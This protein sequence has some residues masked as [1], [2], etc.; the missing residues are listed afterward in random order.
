MALDLTSL[1][2][3]V[4]SRENAL[5]FACSKD[6]LAALTEKQ[7]DVVRAGVIQNFE[8]TYEL[9]W[10]FIKRW[11]EK[12][13]GSAYIDGVSRKE[14][15]RIAAENHLVGQAAP[16]L[17]YHDARNETADTYNRTKVQEVFE[18]SKKFLKDAREFLKNLEGKND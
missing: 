1:K 11:L 4:A 10:K 9:C 13:L 17:I 12:N 18:V 15:F 6:Q 14:L 5:D 2:E 7:R 8:F 16:W 3:A